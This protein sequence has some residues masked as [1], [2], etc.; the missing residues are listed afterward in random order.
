VTDP[1]FWFD[2]CGKDAAK[3]RAFHEQLCGWEVADIPAGN[4][5]IPVIGGDQPWALLV[6]D[7]RGHMGWFPYVQV[8]DLQ[9]S[10]ENAV[11]LGAT[12]L[13]TGN[14][15]SGRNPYPYPRAG[16]RCVR[17]VSAAIVALHQPKT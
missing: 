8:D 3:L 4:G 14:R 11:E 6:G 17:S 5:S 12:V 16:G 9:G 15:R 2:L 7:G 1:F 13:Q 10:T